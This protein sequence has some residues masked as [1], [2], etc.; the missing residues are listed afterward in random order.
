MERLPAPDPRPQ[1]RLPSAYHI[2]RR[3][4][5]QLMLHSWHKTAFSHLRMPN[6]SE[7]PNLRNSKN[8]LSQARHNSA[9]PFLIANLTSKAME[10][11]C[12]LSLILCE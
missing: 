7:I 4:A 12:V 2:W 10:W 3:I 8:A 6:L 9:Q 11:H 1:A 5:P